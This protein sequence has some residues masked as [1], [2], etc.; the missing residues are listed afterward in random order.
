MRAE[1]LKKFLEYLFPA[2]STLFIAASH[3]RGADHGVGSNFIPTSE[4]RINYEI[5]FIEINGSLNPTSLH[6]TTLLQ[7]LYLA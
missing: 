7:V 6:V 2:K 3:A 1:P 5:N 4:I